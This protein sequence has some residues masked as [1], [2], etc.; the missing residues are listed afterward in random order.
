ML[1]VDP[2]HVTAADRRQGA[3][4]AGRE[5]WPRLKQENGRTMAPRTVYLTSLTVIKR[6]LW[7][8]N[9]LC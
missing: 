7:P 8:D 1:A 4:P 3:A 6:D 9:G 5:P 2:G